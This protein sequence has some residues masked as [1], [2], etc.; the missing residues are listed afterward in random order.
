MPIQLKTIK[1]TP[2]SIENYTKNMMRSHPELSSFISRKAEDFANQYVFGAGDENLGY[3]IGAPI[4][5]GRGIMPTH[6]LTNGL[7]STLSLVNE[8][9]ESTNPTVFAVTPNIGDMLGRSNFIKAGT[10]MQPFM[11]QNVTKDVMISPNTALEDI[12]Y[13]L[14]LSGSFNGVKP[15]IK[16]GTKHYFQQPQSVYIGQGE[17]V[18]PEEIMRDTSLENITRN[19]EY[20]KNVNA[21][22]KRYGYVPLN[23]DL[24]NY[25]DRIVENAVKDRITQHNSF[26]RGVN[27]PNPTVGDG[28]VAKVI[29]AFRISRGL[30]AREDPTS[31]HIDY[32]PEELVTKYLDFNTTKGG[33]A[34]IDVK[35]DQGTYYVSTK[36]S[37]NLGETFVVRRPV[38][39]SENR[40]N[41][42]KEND[43]PLNPTTKIHTALEYKNL[44]GEEAPVI[45]SE[46]KG[47]FA[48]FS[49]RNDTLAK[50]G[51]ILQKAIADAHPFTGEGPNPWML[52]GDYSK[53]TYALRLW[54]F[55]N[56]NI[57]S[58]PSPKFIV[59]PNTPFNLSSGPLGGKFAAAWQNPKF[60]TKLLF[61]SKLPDLSYAAYKVQYPKTLFHIDKD[62]VSTAFKNAG[63]INVRGTY[64][65]IFVGESGTPAAEVQYLWP[66]QAATRVIDNKFGSED[67]G[68][69]R[70]KEGG[71]LKR[72]EVGKSGIHIKK[73]NEGKFT[74]SA[75][76]A[77]MGVQEY[78]HK[79]MND[80]DA[81]PLQKKRANFAIQAKKWKK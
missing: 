23:L 30:P 36:P 13:S 42:I 17:Y 65:P 11:G 25:G 52:P 79:V 61:Q 62:A 50:M 76:K 2:Q 77:G 46:G 57:M 28:A 18:S 31:P 26:L 70:K 34:D 6:N 72:V 45:K 10:V 39:F 81:S 37:W 21:Y 56:D 64:G 67:V 1:L 80:P 49:E 75:K 54:N 68:I 59:D 24:A 15:T 44:T 12:P 14:R 78:A 74:D 38:T 27:D 29:N 9:G 40:D 16:I 48:Y 60:F 3:L 58:L 43:E 55:M 19:R 51:P 33:R 41:W 73:K 35:D 71:I 4:A 53:P 8:L 22:F 63:V 5:Q 47:S 66:T 32:N 20:L 69:S 7:R